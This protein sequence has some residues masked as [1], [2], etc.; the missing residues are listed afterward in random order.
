MCSVTSARGGQKKVLDPTELELQVV[1]SSYVP[2]LRIKPGSSHVPPSGLNRVP[3]GA[4][5]D[6]GMVRKEKKSIP[7]CEFAETLV[8][9]FLLKLFCQSIEISKNSKSKNKQTARTVP[10]KRP[11]PG[12][13]AGW[14]QR[15]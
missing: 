9:A 14:L 10:Q 1:V 11:G 5:G 7:G 2:V 6:P 4:H 8:S 13:G 3:V 15:I 12:K